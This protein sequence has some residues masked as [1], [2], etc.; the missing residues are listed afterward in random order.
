MQLNH[1]PTAMSHAFDEPNL[2]STAGLVPVMALAQQTGLQDLTQ[3]MVTVANT[4]GD[5]GANAG[6]K[7]SSLVAGMAAGADSID[8]MDLLRHGGMQSL[9]DQVY[10]PSTLGSHLR[11]YTHGH[12]KQLAAVSSR[13]VTRLGEHAP[14]LSVTQPA[15]NGEN[16]VFVDI[17]DTVIEVYS[18]NKQGAGIGYNKVRGLNALLVTASTFRAP[19]VIV[20]QQLRKGAAN[21]VR[22][23]NKM[24]SD[25]LATLERMP[26]HNAPMVVR[27]DSAFYSAKV[28]KAVL[29]NNA[30]FSVT[31]PMNNKVKKAIATIK[32]TAW[33]TIKYPRAI[34]DDQTRQWISE[35]E[36]AEVGFTAFSS[37]PDKKARVPGRLVVR[38]VPEKNAKKLSAGQDPMFAM[39]RYHGFFTTIPET[40]LTTVAADKMHRQHAIIELV[41]S[42]LKAG[43]LAHMP[44]GMFQAN[45]AWLVSAAMTHNL[46]RTAATMIGGTM[47]KARSLSIRQKIL[48][49]PARIAHRARRV[50]LHLPTHWKWATAFSR[51]WNTTLSPPASAA[52]T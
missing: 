20:G 3:D 1:T 14:L 11:E 9:F 24:L 34:W 44:S 38:R 46:I 29:A 49:I 21:S 50:I 40:V 26:N 52:S 5:K 35:A 8:D 23:A 4:G 48:N 39:H 42:E 22:G 16:M 7:I 31:V 45:A 12:V 37:N 6:A 32:E 25:S 10:A 36:V 51:L 30:D 15:G 17:D 18:P 19:P 43:P 28:A 41:N 27:A 13:F 2:V 47:A 33:T